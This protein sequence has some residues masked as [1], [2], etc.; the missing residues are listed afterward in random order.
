[1]V[2]ES[3]RRKKNVIDIEV[4]GGLLRR[5][6][7][8]WALFLIANGIGLI[9]WVRMFEAP[10]GSWQSVF[11]ETFYRF[12]PVAIVS[13]CVFPAFIWDMSRVTNRFAGP[14][15]R[16]RSAL[17]DAVNGKTPQ[18]LHFRTDDYWEDLA[19]DFNKLV[20]RLPSSQNDNT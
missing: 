11:D 16:L 3:T 1:M 7:T 19:S 12:I 10:E 5:M 9:A 18:P 4:Q 8:Q 6:S 14:V 17:S 2:T 15:K 20:A 13:L